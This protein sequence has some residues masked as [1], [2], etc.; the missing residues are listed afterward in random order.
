MSSLPVPI[1]ATIIGEGASGGAVAL[2]FAD[3]VLML[4]NAIYEVIA[5]ESAATILYRN[6]EK[7]QQVA[8]QLK[9]TATDC[10]QLG[11][12]DAIIPE[13]LSGIHAHPALVMLALQQRL[14]HTLQELEQIP[15][16]RLLAQRYRKFRRYG[17]FLHKQYLL[18][19]ASRSA[20]DQGQSFL[21]QLKA[22][23]PK[24][25]IA[26]VAPS[27]IL[28]DILSIIGISALTMSLERRK[29]HH[30]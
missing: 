27:L 15:V 20:V 29:R 11:V 2:A 4:Q 7:A 13:P 14:L 6:A 9:L 26:R 28:W 12:I 30:E 10:L 19:R 8:E 3:R 5:P 21:Q 23:L 18:A 1:V 16:K 25:V 24:T 17:R 22:W